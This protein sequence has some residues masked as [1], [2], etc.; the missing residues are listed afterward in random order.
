VAAVI[1]L[2]THAVVW[3]FAGELQLFPKKA[4]DA[5]EKNELFISPMVS[6][7]LNYLAETDRILVPADR[8]IRELSSSV[9]LSLSTR[10]FGD[11]IAQAVVLNW[12]RDP[13][14][15]IIT[16]QAMADQSPLITK[17][18]TIRNHYRRALWD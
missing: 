2:D 1:H 10:P 4:L 16:A 3:L 11:V 6:L 13:F 8:V 5:M 18:S 15:R 14:D 7:E 17:D 9:G 12:T